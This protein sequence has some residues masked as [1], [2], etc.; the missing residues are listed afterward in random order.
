M[1]LPRI[2]RVGSCRIAVVLVMRWAEAFCKI[3]PPSGPRTYPYLPIVPRGVPVHSKC[4]PCWNS[5]WGGVRFCFDFPKKRRDY[6]VSNST[7][8]RAVEVITV[9]V[10]SPM[11]DGTTN[12]ASFKLCLDERPRGGGVGL[13]LRLWVASAGAWW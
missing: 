12:C 8:R 4:T 3:N 7:P 11:V 13:G 5:T 1:S 10:F 6:T 2:D 9:S